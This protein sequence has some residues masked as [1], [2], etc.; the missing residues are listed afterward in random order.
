MHYGSVVL[1]REFRQRY[2]SDELLH[3]ARLLDVGAM[4]VA[5]R[6]QWFGVPAS[7]RPIFE[8]VRE[9]VGIDLGEGPGVDV[10]LTDPYR[11]PFESDSFD[12]VLSGQTLEHAQH[13]WRA[14]PEMARVLKPGGWLCVIAPWKWKVH[15]YPLDCWRILADGMEVLLREAGL[16]V[17]ECRMKRNDTI[18]IARK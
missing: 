11:Y 3:R 14:V 4:A 12:I 15:R 13:P 17:V 1:M 2:V 9:Y 5:T 10:V 6:W 18:G 16:T 7:Y 8:G